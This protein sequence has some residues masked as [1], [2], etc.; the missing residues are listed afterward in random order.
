[1]EIKDE[2]SLGCKRFENKDIFIGPWSLEL[3]LLKVIAITLSIHA[4]YTQS[5]NMKNID[6]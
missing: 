5:R 3:G 1:M 4:P 2:L 6:I